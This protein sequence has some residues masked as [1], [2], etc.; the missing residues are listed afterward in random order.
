[1]PDIQKVKPILYAPESRVYHSVG[2]LVG[3][4]FFLGKV[5]LKS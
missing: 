1:M 3:K 2:L 5:Y 4:A